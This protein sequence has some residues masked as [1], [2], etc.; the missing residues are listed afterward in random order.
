MVLMPHP[1]RKTLAAIAQ[2][3]PTR[4]RQKG[5]G[6]VEGTA[7]SSSKLPDQI[8][9]IGAPEGTQ[10]VL[11][12]ARPA[13]ARA[14]ALSPGTARLWPAGTGRDFCRTRRFSAVRN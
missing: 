2:S 5:R 14:A 1:E 3:K 10:A 7:I 6:H 13:H 9:C 11:R 12:N 4:P 8:G